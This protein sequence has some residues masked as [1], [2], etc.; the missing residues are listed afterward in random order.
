MNY[1]Y[2]ESADNSELNVK[3][4]DAVYDT[5]EDHFEPYYSTLSFNDNY[6][7]YCVLISYRI[8]NGETILSYET[9]RIYLYYLPNYSRVILDKV[10]TSEREKDYSFVFDGALSYIDFNIVAEGELIEYFSSGLK[11][12]F[13][14]QI[15]SYDRVE[16]VFYFE[17][18]YLSDDEVLNSIPF[19]FENEIDSG[20]IMSEHQD[21]VIK[22]RTSL[23]DMIQDKYGVIYGISRYD[24]LEIALL[25]GE[26]SSF[27]YS[28]Y[29]NDDIEIYGFIN[30]KRF[31]LLNDIS[32]SS[33]L[34]ISSLIIFNG[35]FDGCGYTI[36]GLNVKINYLGYTKGIFSSNY[37]YIHDVRFNDCTF[38]IGEVHK[39]YS[40]AGLL[41][42][43]NYG[44][45][46]NVIVSGFYEYTLNGRDVTNPLT[47]VNAIYFY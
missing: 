44:C 28:D 2:L 16:Y 38:I 46:E 45:I 6:G 32:C 29:V 40:Y 17:L 18:I 3:N 39:W 36:S 19:I 12:Y 25:F 26:Y 22:V 1:L 24:Q 9:T 8:L 23:F 37:G 5:F 33:A 15:Y 7:Y 13:T 11:Y 31:R 10:T 20:C 30:D 14:D 4:E 42:A 34:E 27:S 47:T 43:N 21:C 41:T 35:D